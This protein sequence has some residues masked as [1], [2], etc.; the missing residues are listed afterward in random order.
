MENKITVYNLSNMPTADVSVFQELQEDFKIYD[1]EK[2]QK[3]QNIILARGF[4]YAFK[5]W[6]DENGVLWIIDA[7][8]R[9][10]ALLELKKKGYDIPPV[11]YEE[12]YAA[13]KREAVEEIAAYNSEFATKNP[14]TL[15]FEKYDIGLDDLK[16]FE[17][18]IAREVKIESQPDNENE[19]QSGG[20]Y[21]S[22]QT[23]TGLFN[24]P[25]ITAKNQYGV[26]VMCE[27]AADQ[28]RVFNEL[29]EIGHKC[30]IV[31]T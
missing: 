3:L 8:Q 28:E 16:M 15:L 29:T 2:N 26:I 25:G 12:I 23:E 22:A 9:K 20:D 5:A 11:P 24:D 21:D 1:S 18:N 31:V 17:L 10:R 30:K 27:T 7:H 13:N 6:R 19:A 14:D 4:K